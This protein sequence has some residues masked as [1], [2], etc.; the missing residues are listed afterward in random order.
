MYLYLPESFSSE[1]V[2]S[3]KT[4][5]CAFEECMVEISIFVLSKIIMVKITHVS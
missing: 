2:L 1:I 3:L 4:N 5:A